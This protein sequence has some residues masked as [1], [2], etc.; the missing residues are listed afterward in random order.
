MLNAALQNDLNTVEK[1]VSQGADINYNDPPKPKMQTVIHPFP[2]GSWYL[3]PSNVSGL[4]LY[5]TYPVFP[6]VLSL[7]CDG[8]RFQMYHPDEE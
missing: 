3:R 1:L 2:G 6:D 7:S 4:L 5:A 8:E